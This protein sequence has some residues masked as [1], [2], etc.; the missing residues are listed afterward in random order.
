MSTSSLYE[1]D[2][3]EE[4]SDS[5]A[6]NPPERDEVPERSGSSLSRLRQSSSPEQDEENDPSATLSRASQTAHSRL[7][8]IRRKGLTKASVDA[9][10]HLL[11]ELVDDLSPTSSLQLDD[12]LRVSSQL[13]IVTWTTSEKETFF[14]LLARKG[15]N[16]IREIADAIGSKSE[17]EV[18]EYL[19]LLHKGLELQQ[20]HERHSR[21]ATFIDIPAAA[22]IS[23][24]CCLALDEFSEYL[25]L[26]QQQSDDR[27]GMKKHGDFWIINGETAEKVEEQIAS[28]SDDSPLPDSSIFL[29][30]SLLNIKR[31]IQLSERFFMNFG[32]SRFEDNWVNVAFKDESPS[33]TADAFADFYALTVS[34]TRRIV[35]SAL[36]FAISRIRNISYHKA[37]KVKTRDIRAALDVLNMKHNS[38]DFWVGLARRCSLEVAD[39]RHKKGWKADYMGYDEVED[40][41]SGRRSFSKSRERS[42][43]RHLEKNN[44][45]DDNDDVDDDDDDEEQEENGGINPDDDDEDEY[46]EED[47]STPPSP[48]SADSLASS[49]SDEEAYADQEDIYAEYIDQ[50]A[51][52]DE[53]LRIRELLQCPM[54]DTL[55]PPVIKTEDDNDNA[56]APP[57]P[58]AGR[59][60]KQDL[61]DW[62]DRTIYRS[63]WEEYGGSALGEINEELAE[64]RRKRR[65]IEVEA[66]VRF[67]RS[68]SSQRELRSFAE[69]RQSHDDD[70]DDDDANTLDTSDGELGEESHYE[71]APDSEAEAEAAEPEMT[72]AEKRSVVEMDIEESAYQ[73]EGTLSS[74][75][76]ASQRQHPHQR[77]DS[78]IPL[79]LGDGEE[80]GSSP[81]SPPGSATQQLDSDDGG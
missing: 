16:G 53:E 51:S 59:K 42:A 24:E 61:V 46:V 37:K 25:T 50:K 20:L 6:R 79:S 14:N 68:R 35:Q 73:A 30:A 58:V 11:R 60:T 44:D 65:R 78:H 40:A 47:E 66:P 80:G 13:G 19:R 77:D 39:I 45:G 49:V 64:N 72:E 70:A 22:E 36:F 9:Y 8:V 41:L 75:G 71:E 57:K 31:W 5:D 3:D 48:R 55:L 56:T 29:S 26:L 67:T 27:A 52:R 1:P 17:L 23:D 28:S 32:G 43:S 21:S 69:R 4:A 7:R 62:R 10:R 34:I 2:E 81:G 18:Q 15:K 54:L 63:E 38:F 33:L 12:N 74:P 76:D